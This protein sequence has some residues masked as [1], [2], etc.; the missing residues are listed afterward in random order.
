MYL[1]DSLG[2][3]EVSDGH[4][5]VEGASVLRRIFNRTRNILRH[6]FQRAVSQSQEY[7]VISFRLAFDSSS[8]IVFSKVCNL[9]SPH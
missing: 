2:H 6:D 7:D 9:T 8:D 5:A 4:K 1:C 3:K